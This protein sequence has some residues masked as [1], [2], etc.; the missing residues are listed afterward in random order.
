MEL[1]TAN[2]HPVRFLPDPE[3][4][5]SVITV[6][7][8]IAPV[9]TSL[10]DAG[11]MTYSSCQHDGHEPAAIEM[12]TE[13]ATKLSPLLSSLAGRFAWAEAVSVE[14]VRATGLNWKTGE[15]KEF[16][17]PGYHVLRF[18]LNLADG[19]TAEIRWYYKG[20]SIVRH[21]NNRS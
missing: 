5:G 18:P 10:W 19:L 9:V 17:I 11:I 8:A 1:E 15:S 16:V 12:T 3:N 4:A 6:D 2:L 21:I 7:E 20:S 13:N 14:P